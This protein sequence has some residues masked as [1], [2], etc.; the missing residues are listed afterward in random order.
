MKTNAV[1]DIR[2]YFIQALENEEF[3]IDKKGDAKIGGVP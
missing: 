3:V 1:R 2:E